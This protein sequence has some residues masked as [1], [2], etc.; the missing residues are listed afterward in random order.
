MYQ[1]TLW[2]GSKREAEPTPQ[3]AWL[4]V[5]DQSSATCMIP[6]GDKRYEGAMRGQEGDPLAGQQWCLVFII[7]IIRDRVW[8]NH[9]SLQS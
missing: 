2:V 3:K 1:Q 7:I 9:R 6:N 8:C 4:G 5:E